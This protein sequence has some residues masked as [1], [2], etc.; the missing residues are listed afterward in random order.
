MAQAS[1]SVRLKGTNCS[2]TIAR[3][4]PRVVLLTLTGRDAGELGDGPFRELA[5]DLDVP[6]E[7]ELFID[8]RAGTGAT[9]DV[10]GKWALWLGANKERFTQVSMLTGSRF[11]QLTA[12]VVK[13][14]AELGEKMRLYTEA[15]AFEGALRA[16]V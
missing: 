11:I 1:E 12:E 10:S 16:A 2:L 7:I 6:G 13:N 14:Y 3:P 8:A 5:K 15:A 9:L 4:A